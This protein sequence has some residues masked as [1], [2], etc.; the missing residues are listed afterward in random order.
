MPNKPKPAI[1]WRLLPSHYARYRRLETVKRLCFR[2]IQERRRREEDR[3]NLTVTLDGTWVTDIPSFWLSL[4]EAINGLH[5]YFGWNLDALSD[6]LCGGFG[7]LPPLTIHLT[8]YEKVREALDY[9]AWIRFLAEGIRD[10]L[11][12]FNEYTVE[13]L[14][15]MGYFGDGSEADIAKWRFIYTAA[16]NDQ[17]F[18]CGGNGRPFCDVLLEI[19]SARGAILLPGDA[20]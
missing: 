14:A 11:E 12:D 6:C 20:T 15:R 2:S 5:G 4:G 16:L 9:H 1:D 8:H 10:F 19:L 7:A 18:E 17:P 3:S 13:E